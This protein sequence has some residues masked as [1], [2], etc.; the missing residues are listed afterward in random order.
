[1]NVSLECTSVHYLPFVRICTAHTSVSVLTEQGRTAKE[2]V[3][4][5][6]EC[7]YRLYTLPRVATSEKG[8]RVSHSRKTVHVFKGLRSPDSLLPTIAYSV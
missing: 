6:T 7:A 5:A 2:T 4:V 8:K 3:Q 1:M